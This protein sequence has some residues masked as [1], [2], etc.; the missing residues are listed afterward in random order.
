MPRPTLLVLLAL[1]ACSRRDPPQPAPSPYVNAKLCAGCHA[2]IARSYSQT[3]MARAFQDA[4]P[5][6]AF[7]TA[8][9]YYHRASDRYYEMVVRGGKLYQRRFQRDPSGAA[10]NVYEKE[11]HYVLGS[12]HHSRTFLHRASDGRLLE[13]PLA[14]YAPTRPGGSGFWAMNPGYDRP[15][16]RAFRRAISH[17][18]MSCHNGYPEFAR[19][20]SQED[21]PMFP[22][23]LPQGIDCQRCHGPGRAHVE[24]AQRKD[25]ANIGASILNPAKLPRDRQMEVCLQCH[26]ESTSRA[27]PYSIIRYGRRPFSYRP[28]E[29]LASHVLH[30]ERADA[31]QEDRF[32]IAHAAYRLRK[33]ACFAASRMTC[34]TCH[35]PHQARRGAGAVAHYRAACQGCHARAHRATEDCTACHMPR[36]RT[37]DVVHVVMTD[38]YIQRRKPARDL[39]APLA[40]Q[41]DSEE[42]A[43]RGPVVP[44]YPASL[45]GADQLYEAAAQVAEGANLT[46]GI[47]KLQS[48]IAAHKPGEARFY[49]ELA[50]AQ[51]RAGEAARAVSLYEEALRR[52]PDYDAAMRG[53][54]LARK[55]MRDYTGAAAALQGATSVAAATLRGEVLLLAGKT[56]EAEAVLR[57]AV[58]RDPDDPD[59]RSNWAQ[60]LLALG[61]NEDSIRELKEA[62]RI[63]PAHPVANNNLANALTAAGRFDQAERYYRLAIEIR[64]KYAE[65]H[66]NYGSAL[67]SRERF[68]EAER[69]L[70]SAAALDPSLA[71]AH[72]NLGNL[73][74]MRGRHAQAAGHFRRAI[75]A[76]PALA[77]AHLNL[78]VS[79]SASGGSEAE[80][81][82]HLRVAAASGDREVR[83]AAQRALAA[84]GR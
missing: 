8:Q 77:S 38:H 3:G 80:V 45:A 24:A 5:G 56:A 10:A 17:E 53:L 42:T 14:W 63:D 29:P 82:E 84:M 18:C 13:M 54:A 31:A 23:A 41:R 2:A 79:L 47:A 78:A 50:K 64:P 46:E 74:G 6:P 26:L 73:A 57:P 33:S 1:A 22:A 61:R 25:T 44:Y 11:A 76:D 71:A 83:G 59:A 32:E 67:A 21:A 20:P 51:E 40:E 37:D 49:Y 27:L 43:Y 19:P 69:E 55:E 52:R 81:V 75:A 58:V 28:D 7:T 72:N 70:K 66:F 48:A 16:H 9:P 35:D 34:T 68:V 60:A 62:L 39:L 36:R 65:A 12:G 15:D 4:R 30:F